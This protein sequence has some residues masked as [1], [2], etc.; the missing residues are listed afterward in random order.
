[1]KDLTVTVAAAQVRWGYHAAAAL[2]DC[3]VTRSEEIWNLRGTIV[4]KN[5]LRLS[6]QPLSLVVTLRNGSWT[7][8]VTEL[9]TMDG[10]LTARLGPK[11]FSHAASDSPA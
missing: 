8:P 5:D 4:S 7:W 9:Q 10:V 11:E 6:Q 1:M 2:R 3:T